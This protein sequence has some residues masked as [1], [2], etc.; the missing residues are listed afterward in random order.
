M[1]TVLAI[2]GGGIR[3]VIPA[4]ILT[5]IERRTGR[6]VAEMFDLLVGTSTGGILA[7]GLAVK[8][9]GGRP[10]YSAAEILDFYREE[11]REI[12]RRSLWKGITSVAGIV[13]EKYDEK[14][15]ERILKK[16]FGDATLTDCISPVVLTAYDIERRH[17]YFFKTRR[18]HESKDRNHYLRDA[19]RA[20]TAVPSYFEPE[21]VP[22]LAA[23]PTR[24]VLIDGGVFV[25]NPALC[26]YVEALDMGGSADDLRLVSLGTGVHTRKIPLK[27]ARDWGALEWARP[28]IS[29]MMDG[30]ADAADYHL[31]QLMPDAGAGAAQRY[32]RFDIELDAA[33]DDMD[34][35]TAGNIRN[36]EAAAREIL[37]VQAAEFDRLVAPLTS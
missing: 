3:G 26:A 4:V 36:L 6:T 34:D 22:S 1:R 13:D 20:T 2:D 30:Q 14:P 33:S 23:R 25:A 28:V 15:L 24:R 35:A 27:E 10:R 8:G 29:I 9:D 37:R 18:A 16:R 5:E 11:G 21:K 32:F 19:V 12:F 17:P 7:A 31:R